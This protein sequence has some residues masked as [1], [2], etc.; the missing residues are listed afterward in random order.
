MCYKKI[1]V[2]VKIRTYEAKKAKKSQPEAKRSK[3]NG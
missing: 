3:R 1:M 2:G